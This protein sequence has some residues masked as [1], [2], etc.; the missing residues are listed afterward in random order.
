MNGPQVLIQSF[1][2]SYKCELRKMFEVQQYQKEIY[3]KKYN[4]VDW[5]Q[6]F[7]TGIIHTFLISMSAFKIFQY[8]Y[9]VIPFYIP[10]SWLSLEI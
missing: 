2:D 8:I 6:S 10:V 1:I 3:L 5:N 7:R 9:I 4:S